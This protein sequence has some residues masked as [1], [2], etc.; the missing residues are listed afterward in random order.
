MLFRSPSDSM[1]SS[2]KRLNE[3]PEERGRDRIMKSHSATHLN[4]ILKVIIR[5]FMAGSNDHIHMLKAA[6]A[7]M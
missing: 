1:D 2:K 6:C 4:M 7:W 5:R 3:W